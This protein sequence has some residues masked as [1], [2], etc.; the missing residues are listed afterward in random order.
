MT[1]IQDKIIEPKLGLLELASSSSAISEAAPV[2]PSRLQL[3]IICQ[4]FISC[5]RK[6]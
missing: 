3:F 4:R 6:Q 1:S 2:Q 5:A